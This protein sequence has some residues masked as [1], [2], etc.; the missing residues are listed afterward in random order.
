MPIF[1]S[2][3]PVKLAQQMLAAGVPAIGPTIFKAIDEI[4]SSELWL[5]GR[6]AD[7]E[8]FGSFG[9]FAHARQPHGLGVRDE[10][11]FWWIRAALLGGDHYAELADVIAV[12]AKERGRPREN[13][14]GDDISPF[15]TITKGQNCLNYILR[16]LKREH[17]DVLDAVD[18]CELTPAQAARQVGIVKPPPQQASDEKALNGLWELF[19]NATVEAQCALLEAVGAAI[20]EP[21]L[22]V[23]WRVHWDRRRSA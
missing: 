3:D 22:A 13:V 14:T 15:L 8:R 11:S 23:R 20:D 5:A 21:R 1:Q 18:K 2:R 10:E 4:V 9:L 16:R 6:T 12:C 17:P 7:G 19:S